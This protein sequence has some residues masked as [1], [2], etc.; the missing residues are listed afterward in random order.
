MTIV[1]DSFANFIYTRDGQPRGLYV[2]ILTEAV[3]RRLG[4]PVEFVWMPWQRAQHSVAEGK[5]D[6]MVTL[7]TPGRQA[8]AEAS[9]VPV[10]VAKI[11]AFTRF[12][13][14]QFRQMRKIKSVKDLEDYQM[15][16]YLGDGWAETNLA[17][18]DVDYGANDLKTVLEKLTRGRGDLF[19]QVEGAAR[20]Y[21]DK[22][23]Y[24][25]TV[26][27]IPGVYLDRIKFRLLIGKGSP[28]LPLMS[29]IDE[30]LKALNEDGTAMRI[31]KNYGYIK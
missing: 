27:Q 24:S 9:R 15:L 16:T 23:G 10:A 2:D 20:Y 26:A 8:Y 1:Y 30:A 12:D 28:F 19:L 25:D 6:A 14:P 31:R 4:T 3:Q 5:A 7:A 21:R 29:G 11:A 18:Q 17:G 13:H 22:L